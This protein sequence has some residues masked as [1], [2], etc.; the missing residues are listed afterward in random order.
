MNIAFAGFR[1][2]HI[3]G[4]YKT[5]SE[6]PEVT[7]KGC[8][9]DNTPAREATIKNIGA[10]FCYNT[11]EQLLGDPQVDAVAIGDYFSRRGSMVIKALE[12]GKHVICDKPVCT[13]LKEL[14]RIEELVNKT[15][16]Q[17]CCML[18]LRYCTPAMEVKAMIE[19]GV[20]GDVKTVNFTGQHCLDYGNRPAWYFEEGKQ[21]GTINDIA[22]HGIDLIRF[23]TGKN[24]TK[25][26]FAKCWN[27]FATQEPDFKDGG[28]FIIEMD[29]IS[30]TS[31]VTYS[32]PKFSGTLPTYWEFCIWG[33]EGMISFNLAEECIK[34]YKGEKTVIPCPAKPMDYLN[35]FMKEIKGE[36]TIMD[37]KGVLDSQRQTLLIQQFA[38]KQ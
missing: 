38:D 31:D 16:L 28:Q 5:A 2:G 18:D 25:V 26:N 35:A 8:F 21:G 32:A 17:V 27:A 37:T 12:S 9:E 14:D 7:I 20:I 6:H 22:I 4:L 1:H 23:M 33:T 11:Y 13:D 3:L 10:E 29:G 24:L 30:V 15:G 19:D 36:K 34:L